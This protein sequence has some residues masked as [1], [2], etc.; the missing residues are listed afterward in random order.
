MVPYYGGKK[1][2]FYR[3]GHGSNSK[4]THSEQERINKAKK[5][6]EGVKNTF[7]HNTPRILEI[8]EAVN[9]YVQYYRNFTM[10][11]GIIDRLQLHEA[12]S[13]HFKH[14]IPP[15]KV[16]LR[17]LPDDTYSNIMRHPKINKN[18]RTVIYHLIK[19]LQEDVRGLTN[20]DLETI[21]PG[22]IGV[23]ETNKTDIPSFLQI[24]N[25]LPSELKKDLS[26]TEKAYT[27]L[28]DELTPLEPVKLGSG[29]ISTAV[30][31]L[32]Y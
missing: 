25:Y 1:S 16:I 21:V 26:Q 6:K 2:T 22:I 29:Y 3:K 12:A 9:F 27:K 24:L 23:M 4:R 15:N 11:G 5:R 31:A 10:N 17:N 28:I 14:S 20:Y 32:N 13:K 7:A 8:N 30:E 18:K 19:Y